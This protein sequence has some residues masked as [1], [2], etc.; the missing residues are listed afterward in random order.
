MKRNI[1]FF[2]S[3]I[4]IAILCLIP[5][6]AFADSDVV[7]TATITEESLKDSYEAGDEIVVK[8]DLTSCGSNVGVVKG[9]LGFDKEKLNIEKIKKGGLGPNILAQGED[10]TSYGEEDYSNKIMYWVEDE[11]NEL[12]KGSIGTITFTV[13]DNV[14]GTISFQ[15]SNLTA[16]TYDNKTSYT[17]EG[18]GSEERTIILNPTKPIIS[19]SDSEYTGF[20][21]TAVVAN[22]DEETMFISGNKQTNAGTYTITVTSKTGIW[23]DGTSDAVSCEWII[24][25]ATI[26]P[27]AKIEER[28]YIKG[29][30]DATISNVIFEGLVNN[31]KLLSGVDYNAI[32][33]FTSDNAGND[34]IANV[35]LTLVENAKTSNYKLEK[36]AFASKGTINPVEIKDIELAYDSIEYTGEELKPEVTIEGLVAG[37]D[38]SIVY[39]NNTNAGIATVTVTGIGNYKGSVKKEFTI[40]PKSITPSVEEIED[41]VF[42]GE[43]IEPVVIVMNGT[44]KLVKDIHYIVSYSNNTNVTKSAEVTITARDGGNYAFE[45]IEKTFAIT[46]YQLKDNE[47]TLEKTAY[48]YTGEA[49]EPEVSVVLNGKTLLKG[50]DYEVEY[51]D[52][53]EISDS[54]KVTIS[55]KG[56]YSGIIKKTI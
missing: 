27:S 47:V 2:S 48:R 9:F 18:V 30:T 13:K 40:T 5:V 51:S 46:E 34:K 24:N 56:N 10:G 32:A 43:K 39:S 4:L 41:Q 29:N 6:V 55:G 7:V 26:V 17:T 16:T 25:P 45:Y 36:N 38:F 21:Q 23:K 14:A 15:I 8:I 12:E 19:A 53:T 20:E 49:I 1:R 11:Y 54:A 33:Q 50:S 52:N 3:L 35:Y 44:E 42:T 31:E 22:Y 28:D 37:K